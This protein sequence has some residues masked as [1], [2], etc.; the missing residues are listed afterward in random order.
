MSLRMTVFRVGG[1]V[2][3]LTLITLAAHANPYLSKLKEGWSILEK[4][5]IGRSASIFAETIHLDPQR[6]AAHLSLAVAASLQQDWK[7]AL[8]AFQTVLS[9]QPRDV[10]GWNGLGVVHL[11]QGQ[12]A[13]AMACF[14]KALEIEPDYAAARVHLAFTLCLHNLPDRALEECERVMRS[15]PNADVRGFAQQTRALALLLK[16]YHDEALAAVRDALYAATAARNRPYPSWVALADTRHAFALIAHPLFVAQK[17]PEPRMMTPLPPVVHADVP[18]SP[19][20]TNGNGQPTPPKNPSP[21]AP[22]PPTI[23]VTFSPVGQPPDSSAPDNS[24][25]PAVRG[26][27]TVM[28]EVNSV[29]PIRYLRLVVGG[30]VRAVFNAPPYQWRWNTLLDN[31]G[32]AE[33]IVRLYGATGALLGESK[34]PVRVQNRSAG[35]QPAS[36]SLLMTERG[37]NPAS[38]MD[39]EELD[40]VRQ[41]ARPLLT[42]TAHPHAVR[43]LKAKIHAAQEDWAATYDTLMEIYADDPS[44]LDVRA[45]I[46]TLRERLYQVP[47]DDVL[48]VQFVPGAGNVVALT[49]DDGPRSPYTERILETLRQYN[50]KA[51]FFVVGKMVENHPDLT[52]AILK[53]GHEFA[54]HSYLHYNMAR[55]TPLE[56]EREILRCEHAVRKVTGK[57]IRLFR[58]PG[59]RYDEEVRQAINGLGYK[60]IFW[61]A[62][63]T[64]FPLLPPYQ[65]AEKLVERVG[66]GGIILLHNGMDKSAWVLPHLLR[67]LR[68]RGTRIVTVSELLEMR[69]RR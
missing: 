27:V 53:D 16:R 51:T 36:S 67:L 52:L 61:T 39:G 25:P 26:V 49:F 22:P 57:E 40:F 17:L 10:L 65:I 2:L 29:T 46:L 32:E 66:Q 24:V 33:L 4:G 44:Y 6:A 68:L 23:K 56:L 28:V 5:Q 59:G 64:S 43:Y 30:R 34:F 47:V 38:P 63:I 55:M 14:E 50:V 69:G 19:N 7:T 48:E 12:T 11:Q 37:D 20:V 41:R 62:N 1:S 35:F 31:D 21:V 8:N 54:N 60:T 9:T 13:E 3:C 45:Q 58:P 18:T 42:L 15:N